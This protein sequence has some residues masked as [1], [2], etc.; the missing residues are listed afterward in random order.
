MTASGSGSPSP[1]Q[2]KVA[3]TIRHELAGWLVRGEIHDPRLADA[4]VTISEVRASRDLKH[5]T[6]YV[7]VLGAEGAP[8]DVL[9]AL[10]HAAGA[11]GGRLARALHLKYAPRLTFA[12]D[13]RY[14]EA[15]RI[16]ALLR[17]ARA[18]RD[19]ENGDDGT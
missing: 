7:A 6:A 9:A 1:R 17:A 4:S 5:A 13:D 2:L 18:D 3:E 15:A 10:N 8:T 11:L 19:A 14:D 12:A 16:D